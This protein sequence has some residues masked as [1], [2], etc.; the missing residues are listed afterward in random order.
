VL[1]LRRHLLLLAG[2]GAVLV[3]RIAKAL[4]VAGAA[5]VAMIGLALLAG[6]AGARQPPRPELERAAIRPPAISGREHGRQRSG[7]FRMLHYNSP[8]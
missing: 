3:L 6:E 5:A 7:V 1:V 8:R 4:E 2:K